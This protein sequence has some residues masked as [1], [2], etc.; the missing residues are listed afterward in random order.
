MSV[1]GSVDMYW[2]DLADGDAWAHL[3]RRSQGGDRSAFVSIVRMNAPRIFEL[4]RDMTGGVVAG[5]TAAVATFATAAEHLSQL[6]D[7]SRLVP[8]LCAIARNESARL[9][10]AQRRNEKRDR[11]TYGA[12]AITNVPG[13]ERRAALAAMADV[14]ERLADRDR[15]VVHLA[16]RHSLTGSDLADASGV[17]VVRAYDVLNRTNDAL[18]CS[19]GASLVAARFKGSCDALDR[20]LA[21]VSNKGASDQRERIAQHVGGCT[22]CQGRSEQMLAPL[23]ARPGHLDLSGLGFEAAP[24]SLLT[25]FVDDWTPQ[26]RSAPVRWQADGFP[27]TTVRNVARASALAA[28]V[29]I[30]VTVA[31]SFAGAALIG[32]NGLADMPQ[33]AEIVMTM[34]TNTTISVA[35]TLV[36]EPVDQN[37]GGNEADGSTATS[38]VSRPTITAVPTTASTT[39]TAP[40]ASTEPDTTSPATTDPDTA[41][42]STSAPETT[43]PSDTTEVT[44]TT[45]MTTTTGVDSSTTTVPEPAPATTSTAPGSS[46][47]A[48]PTP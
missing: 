18:R 22:A 14:T 10:S 1:A 40:T 43:E 34:P 39:T 3:M 26:R 38:G 16:L 46:T 48:Q 35:T 4:C 19:V 6:P 32:D 45:D 7:S 27:S 42:S 33:P 11:E 41:A 28:T 47:T 2:A 23:V 8:W 12:A 13:F 5:E 15:L 44:P 29:M 25:R 21:K 17:D 9:A 24:A 31:G 30:S 37:D 36:A 20:V